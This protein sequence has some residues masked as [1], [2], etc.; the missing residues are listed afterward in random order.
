MVNKI[1]SIKYDT[2]QGENLSKTNNSNK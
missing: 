1:M 2:D